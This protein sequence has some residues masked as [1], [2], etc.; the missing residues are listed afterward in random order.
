VHEVLRSPGQA[1]DPETRAFFE[2]RF[3][4]D[5]SK[6]R[7]HTDA[8]AAASAGVVDA[9]AYTVGRDVVFG[10]GQYAPWSR[11]GQRLIAHELTHVIQQNRP[12]S[13]GQDLRIG[14]S[15]D[16]SGCGPEQAA[17]AIPA[18]ANPQPVIGSGQPLLA[19][20]VVAAKV[21]CGTGTHGAPADPVAALEAAEAHAQGLAG[22]AA[23]LAEA[24]SAYAHIAASAYA[25]IAA[26]MDIDVTLSE[27]I[28][29]FYKARFGL[30]PPAR[31]GFMNRLTG[32][33]ERSRNEAISGELEL[34]SARLQLIADI[35]DQEIHYRCIG[36][37]TTFMGCSCDCMHAGMHSD[38]CACAE[39]SAIF[40]C[41]GFWNLGKN[42]MATLLIHEAAHML[43]R[44]VGH[45]GS[46]RDASCY[47]NFVADI[48][49]AP[50]TGPAC[51]APP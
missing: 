22:A 28:G 4:Y 8:R 17:D 15:S 5:F 46:Y 6:V 26:T 12:V 11:A 27:G 24:A 16:Q 23:I 38:A 2:P 7:V 49:G 50:L 30:P 34:L 40:L 35:F 43:W 20:K 37:P 33:V 21:H 32:R 25:H 47:A 3:G 42:A 14:D 1:L 19:R 10:A 45:A 39:V 51:P 41:P 29:P 36:G 31:G 48:F 44:N 9:L 13:T 18:G